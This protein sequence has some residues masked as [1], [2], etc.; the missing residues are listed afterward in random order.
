VD[1]YLL[2]LI[3]LFFAKEERRF[4]LD[5]LVFSGV[6]TAVSTLTLYFIGVKSADGRLLDL[7]RLSPNYLAMYLSPILA[8]ALY[9]FLAGKKVKTAIFLGGAGMIIGFALVLTQSRGALFALLG[10]AIVSAYA[11]L[12]ATKLKFMRHVL[13]ALAFAAFFAGSYLA[14]RPDFVQ[15]SGRVGQSSNIRYYIWTASYEIARAHPVSG[16][17]LSN[18]QNYF[19][20]LTRSRVNYPEFITPEAL[21]AHNLYLHIYLTCGILGLV[22]FVALVVFSK[23]WNFKT[24]A[25]AAF[26]VILFY[27]LIDTPFFRNDLAVLLWIL[28]GIIYAGKF[29]TLNSKS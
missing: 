24:A 18:Y 6:L 12:K 17:G 29:K 22:A 10:A 8:L 23:F 21:T 4:I 7:D 14:F 16:I 27:A 9:L 3:I 20:D 1:G 5:V 28:L 26:L 11:L 15:T 25:S 19:S 2:F 13:F